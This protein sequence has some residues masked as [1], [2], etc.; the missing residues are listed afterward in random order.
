MGSV[1]TPADFIGPNG[2]ETLA[3]KW[4]KL[5]ARQLAHTPPAPFDTQ[6]WQPQ[7]YT[8]GWMF[9]RWGQPTPHCPALL[10]EHCKGWWIDWARMADLPNAR[11][12]QLPR[13]HWMAPLASLSQLGANAQVLG[14]DAMAQYLQSL[15]AQ[16]ERSTDALMVVQLSDDGWAQG[17]EREVQRFFIRPGTDLSVSPAA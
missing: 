14:R 12:V 5:F 4:H 7:A 13:L 1:A 15:W 8:R 3:H 2:V 10:A 6:R 11:Y 16:G 9:Y 17:E